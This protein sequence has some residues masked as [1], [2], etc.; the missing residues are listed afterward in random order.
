MNTLNMNIS[1]VVVVFSIM[2]FWHN[3]RITGVWWL[4][5]VFSYMEFYTDMFKTII[6]KSYSP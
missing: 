4:I 3:L 1:N 2:Q 6:P 5:T